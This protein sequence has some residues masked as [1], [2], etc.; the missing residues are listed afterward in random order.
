MKKIISLMIAVALCF[1]FAVSG[2]AISSDDA[3]VV[4]LDSLMSS[5]NK[6]DNFYDFGDVLMDS[7]ENEL[8]AKNTE[9][10]SAYGFH[11]I[12]LTL[13]DSYGVDTTTFITDFYD[14]Y[15][16]KNG[17]AETPN[18]I[19]FTVDYANDVVNG[20]AV[21]NVEQYI[22]NEEIGVILEKAKNDSAAFDPYSFFNGCVRE[23]ITAYNGDLSDNSDAYTAQN[24]YSYSYMVPFLDLQLAQASKYDYV[25]DFAGILSDS[26][27]KQLSNLAKEK[28]KESGL[29]FGYLTYS[30]AYGRDTQTFTDDFYDYYVSHIVEKGP[31]NQTSGILFAVDMDNREVYI[32]TGGNASSLIPSD[33]AYSLLDKTYQ[34]ASDGDYF[35]CLEKTTDV[36]F[37]YLYPNPW[38]P[39]KTSLIAAAV[40]AVILPLI[41]LAI[42]NKSNKVPKAS[43]YLASFKILSKHD[44][45]LGHREEVLHDFYKQES[46]SGGGGGGHI[47][48]GGG[49]H[50][51]GGHGF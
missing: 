42:H 23:S 2:F 26:E 43:E 37:K 47:S 10:E 44:T 29:W 11:F 30:D 49:S 40:V 9:T 36:T 19:I 45:F 41:L 1:V 6:V 39:T 16:L 20:R 31:E 12:F 3:M 15:I 33:K 14:Y 46:S 25:Y 13:K 24:G 7:A 38:V 28:A 51:G 17:E 4:A 50:G 5:A 48:G 22:T 8:A 35:K 34:Y 32:N 21:G 18:A 27:E